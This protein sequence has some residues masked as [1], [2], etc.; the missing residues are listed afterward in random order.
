MPFSLLPLN[1]LRSRFVTRSKLRM[2]AQHDQQPNSVATARPKQPTDALAASLP[3]ETLA[4]IFHLALKGSDARKKHQAKLALAKTCVGW[5]A[6]AEMGRALEVADTMKAERLG[7]ALREQGDESME[8]VRSL[9]V[10]I[11]IKPDFAPGYQ[12][13]AALISACPRLEK[14]ELQVGGFE[15]EPSPGPLAGALEGLPE[16]REFSISTS[17]ETTIPAA[18]IH[19]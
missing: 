16:L 11:E 7:K 17:F 10:S 4:Q 15:F 8:R 1:R 5:Y 19:G 12:R 3:T 2:E 14:L 13:A 18:V 9:C 6:A